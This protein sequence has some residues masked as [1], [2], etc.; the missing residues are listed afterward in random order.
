[1]VL[2]IVKWPV[3]IATKVQQESNVNSSDDA[4]C[5][6]QVLKGDKD[7]FRVLVSAYKDQVYGVIM[8]QVG[9]IHIA[10][11]LAQDTFVK[12]FVNLKQFKFR[13]SFSTWLTRIALNT[14]N[15]YFSSKRYKQKARTESLEL[16]KHDKSEFNLEDQ[17]DRQEVIK[18]FRQALGKLKA[19]QRE[20]IVLCGLEEKDYQE[21]SEILGVPVGTVRSRLSNA[22]KALREILE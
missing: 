10:E 5:I 19:R 6:E 1:M 17:Q 20:V 12:A 8:R 22:R 11:E 14:T 18:K 9:D 2:L 16:D 4:K 3:L 7:Q 15:T 21:V 13:S